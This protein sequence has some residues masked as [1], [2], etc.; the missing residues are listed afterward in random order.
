MKNMYRLYGVE[1]SLFS[2]KVR[3][4]MNYKGLDYVEKAPNFLDFR[5]F[6]K[7]VNARV[8]PVVETHEGDL[9]A[10]TSLIIEALE[11][12]HPEPSITPSA[13]QVQIAAMLFEAWID[14]VNYIIAGH[15]RWSHDENFPLFRDTM[16]K[17]MF[18]ILPKILQNWMVEKTAV[19]AMRNLKPKMGFT[20]N[21]IPILD[22]WIVELLD[23]LDAHF[24]AHNYLF[25]GKPTVAD[26]ALVGCCYGHLYLDPW[27]RRELIDPR[28][29]LKAYTE[30][31]HSGEKATGDWF[32]AGEFPESLQALLSMMFTQLYSIN[33]QTVEIVEQLILQE[34]KRPGDVLSRFPGKI[35][36]PMLNKTYNK[37]TF[38]YTLWMMQRIQRACAELSEVERESLSDF[39]SSMGV[40]NIESISCGPP[41]ERHGLTVELA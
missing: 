13:G 37:V 28:P 6:A 34:N 26:Y 15:T 33:Q 1:I 41:L 21:Q 3:A 16:G 40:D 32:S 38:S 22:Q 35:D 18:P 20:P 30:R 12:Q 9:L 2:S 7:E 39:F 36:L 10:D 5:R 11:A 14:E 8:M 23:K 4:Y 27:P 17:A 19:A 25:G 24:Q 31:V 29:H